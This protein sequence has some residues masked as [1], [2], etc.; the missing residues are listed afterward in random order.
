L[1]VVR[2]HDVGRITLTVSAEDCEDRS[3]IIEA[4][5]S[6]TAPPGR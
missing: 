1:A 3:V 4:E 6:G 2:P 5:L